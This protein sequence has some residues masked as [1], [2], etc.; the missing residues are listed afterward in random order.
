MPWRPGARSA[1]SSSSPD[2]ARKHYREPKLAQRLVGQPVHGPLVLR[3]GTQR[4]VELDRRGVPVQ[5]RPLEPLVPAL[6]TDPCQLLQQRPAV[7][8]TTLIRT[9]IQILQIDPVHPTPRR[10]VEKPQR[11]ARHLA[12]VRLRDMREHPGPLPEQRLPQL[13][14]A[15][16]RL[17]RNLLVRGELTDHG[18]DLGHIG[19]GGFTNHEAQPAPGQL[20]APTALEQSPTAPP[21]S[22]PLRPADPTTRSAT[23]APASTPEPARGPARASPSSRR[24]ATA[25]PPDRSG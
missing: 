9:D 17:V 11:E 18:M 25:S 5:H 8:G 21:A 14:L 1:R 10:E 4:P 12:L 6:H 22:R 13:R 16:P 2:P 24:S 7:A 23:T 3:P 20:T 15:R 19:R